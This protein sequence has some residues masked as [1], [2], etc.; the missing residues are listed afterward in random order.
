MVFTLGISSHF[1]IGQ[2]SQKR[3]IFKRSTSQQIA[4]SNTI[5]SML[6]VAHNETA[7]QSALSEYILRQLV[8]LFIKY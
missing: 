7:Y 8:H 4:H 2:T 3:E 5:F 1:M 6:S